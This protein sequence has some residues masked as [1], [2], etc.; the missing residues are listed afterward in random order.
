MKISFKIFTLNNK[1]VISSF[2]MIHL[3]SLPHSQEKKIKNKSAFLLKSH[4]PIDLLHTE[5]LTEN[6]S[7]KSNSGSHLRSIAIF[8]Q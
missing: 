2:S 5:P 4:K 8:G 6:F 3:D 1:L 7:R